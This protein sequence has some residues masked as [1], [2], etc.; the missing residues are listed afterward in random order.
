MHDTVEEP[1]KVIAL[2]G[3]RSVNVLRP[4]GRQKAHDLGLKWTNVV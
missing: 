4:E 2:V 3:Q 1:V